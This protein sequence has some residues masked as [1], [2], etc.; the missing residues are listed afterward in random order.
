NIGVAVGFPKIPKQIRISRN[1]TVHRNS[2]GRPFQL[3]S[4]LK[5]HKHA[6]PIDNPLMP[7]IMSKLMRASFEFEIKPFPLPGTLPPTG[8]FPVGNGA[9]GSNNID[10]I[11][12]FENNDQQV[13]P[14]TGVSSHAGKGPDERD[15]VVTVSSQPNL[16]TGKDAIETLPPP[17]AETADEKPE[18][19]LRHIYIDP[20]RDAQ[21]SENDGDVAGI[22]IT[23]ENIQNMK[24]NLQNTNENIQ[25]TNEN[26]QNTNENIQNTEGDATVQPE[27]TETANIAA[28]ENNETIIEQENSDST[29]GTSSTPEVIGQVTP[30]YTAPT[31]SQWM[32]YYDYGIHKPEYIHG[33]DFTTDYPSHVDDIHYDT[34]H[35]P[36]KPSHPDYSKSYFS[37]LF[38]PFKY[39]KR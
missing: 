22:Q 28:Q 36:F 34:Y 1:V 35:S 5:G 33:I 8:F 19:V 23:N 31:P 15:E 37:N 14:P 38:S 16:P 9:M 26:N 6:A 27:T 3:L 24:E 21:S 4:F 18:R 10:N 20:R 30:T 25:N 7:F 2:N 17:A 29:G 13:S 12:Q 39:F 11:F 32:G